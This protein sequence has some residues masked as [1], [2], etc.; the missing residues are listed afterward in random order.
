V[1]VGFG[2]RVQELERGVC[3][4]GVNVGGLGDEV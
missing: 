1:S 4:E 2:G 3:L